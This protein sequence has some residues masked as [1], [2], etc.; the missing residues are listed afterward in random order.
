MHRPVVIRFFR[1][2]LLPVVVGEAVVADLY[3]LEVMAVQA[4]VLVT[5]QMPQAE[6]LVI[7]RLH[8]HPKEQMVALH[9]QVRRDTTAGVAGVQLLLVVL[10]QEVPLGLAVLELPTQLLAHL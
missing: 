6:E 9:Q 1:L 7:P 10:V 8:L 4:A 3:R 5:Q 2:Q